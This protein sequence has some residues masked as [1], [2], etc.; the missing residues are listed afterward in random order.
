[1]SRATKQ[2]DRFERRPN[3]PRAPR[4]APLLLLLT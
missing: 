4:R 2:I 3:L 1:M